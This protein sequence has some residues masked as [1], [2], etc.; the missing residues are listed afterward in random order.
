MINWGKVNVLQKIGNPNVVILTT[1]WDGSSKYT[2]EGMV[3]SSDVK[4]YPIG[5]FS[6][7]WHKN[8]FELIEKS[9]NLTFSNN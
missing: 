5:T 6:K 7:S 8:K 2:F 9:V 1:I 4:E 3:I